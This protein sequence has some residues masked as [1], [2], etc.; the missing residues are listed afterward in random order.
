MMWSKKILLPFHVRPIAGEPKSRLL[1]EG[2][3]RFPHVGHLGPADEDRMQM[4][5]HQTP[6]GGVDVVFVARFAKFV[7]DDA[8]D[9]VINGGAGGKAKARGERRRD[10]TSVLFARE[11][12]LPFK[13]HENGLDGVF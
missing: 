12:M 10:S 13:S 7:K 1:L 8:G 3:H 2:R 9:L 6:G 4:I 11:A 5:G